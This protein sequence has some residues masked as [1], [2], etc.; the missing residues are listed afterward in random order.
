MYWKWMT[1]NVCESV[2]KTNLK[3]REECTKKRMQCIRCSSA[4]SVNAQRMDSLCSGEPL[5]FLTLSSHVKTITF[6]LPSK[7]KKDIASKK[8]EVSLSLDWKHL[9]LAILI[10]MINESYALTCHMTTDT[11][12]WLQSKHNTSRRLN[13]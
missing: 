10:K 2:L 11:N 13:F 1:W 4:H 8:N 3:K 12:V 5:V 9:I 6:N 7:K